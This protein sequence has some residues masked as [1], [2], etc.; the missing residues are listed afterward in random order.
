MPP[1][2]YRFRDAVASSATLDIAR[3]VQ[4][5]CLT[6][7][8]SAVRA[9]YDAPFPDESY[10]VGPRAMPTL[11]PVS[12]DDPASAANRAAWS[13]LHA[14]DKPFLVAFSDGDP[15]TGPMAPVFERL[16][17]GARRR[18]HPVVEGAGH[19]LQEDAPDRLTSEIVAFL[20]AMAS[21][22]EQH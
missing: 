3:F 16:V 1:V 15:I 9:A 22:S 2:W 12:A 4:S 19:F 13:V 5:G 14:W 21:S 18:R 8:T 11:V 17:P 20:R 10:K 7:L 6:T